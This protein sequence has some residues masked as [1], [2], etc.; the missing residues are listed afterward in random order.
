[1]AAGGDGYT[2][3]ASY[4]IKAEYN[5]LMDTLLAYV[6]KLGTVPGTFETRMKVVAEAPVVEEVTVVVPTVEEAPT[7][8]AVVIEGKEVALRA[9]LQDKGFKV[10]FDDANKVVTAQKDTTVLTFTLNSKEYD[11]KDSMSTVG[12]E[13]SA[14]LTVKENVTY[15]NSGEVEAI[16]AKFTPAA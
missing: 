12:G 14:P 9:Y 16:L 13:L 11:A 15:I 7:K 1:M 8:T 10:S 3:F 4:P 5:T 6:E 2:M